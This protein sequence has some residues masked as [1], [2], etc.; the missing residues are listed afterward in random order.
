MMTTMKQILLLWRKSPGPWEI[1]NRSFQ[2]N[3]LLKYSFPVPLE[4]SPAE[5]PL[6]ILQQ[7]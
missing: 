1:I 4:Q 2:W 7:L 6:L 5:L 3:I